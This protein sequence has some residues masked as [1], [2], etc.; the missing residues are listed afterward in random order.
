MLLACMY[1]ISYDAVRSMGVIVVSE[2]LTG[3]IQSLNQQTSR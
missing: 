2:S 1:L 3:Q